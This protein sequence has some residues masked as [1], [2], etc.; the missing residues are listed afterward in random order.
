MHALELWVRALDPLLKRR[1][2]AVTRLETLLD[3]RV[4]DFEEERAL[5]CGGVALL[6]DLVA[7]AADLNGPAD[8]DCCACGSVEAGGHAGLL[9]LAGG[10]RERWH[11]R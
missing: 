10:W 7:R 5:P 1:H 8:L 2:E 6:D 11:A 9:C 3:L 4:A